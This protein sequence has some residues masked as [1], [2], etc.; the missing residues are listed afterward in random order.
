MKN[1]QL[2]MADPTSF[3]QKAC[4]DSG[5]Q[6]WYLPENMESARHD[7]KEKIKEMAKEQRNPG[8]PL[9]NSHISFPLPE[10]DIVMKEM[11]RLGA[12]RRKKVKQ[13]MMENAS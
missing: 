6:N 13:F 7:L 9:F 1:A 2:I 8:C 12:E 3:L 11:N 10:P 5:L 4:L